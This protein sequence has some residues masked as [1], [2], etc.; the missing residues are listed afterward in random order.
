M[1]ACSKRRKTIQPIC[2]H[3]PNCYWHN[4]SCKRKQT[5]NNLTHKK[6]GNRPIP[7]HYHPKTHE[8]LNMILNKLDMIE[9]KI[10]Q[11]SRVKDNKDNGDKTRKNKNNASN[12]NN[13]T[14]KTISLNEMDKFKQVLNNNSFSNNN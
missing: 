11:I 6:N 8:K 12:F 5:H 3:D 7:Q 1:V 9:R 4:R 13:K 2:N 10:H 14:V